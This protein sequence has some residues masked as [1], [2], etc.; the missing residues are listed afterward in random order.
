MVHRVVLGYS[1]SH[2]LAMVI[3]PHI[4]H[5]VTSS[6]QMVAHSLLSKSLL[7]MSLCLMHFFKE[8]A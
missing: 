1:S 3:Y 6:V 4:F 8:R 5:I 7:L 2:R